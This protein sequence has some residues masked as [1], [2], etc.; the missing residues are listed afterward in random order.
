MSPNCFE[1]SESRQEFPMNSLLSIAAPLEGRSD[2]RLS[3][4]RAFHAFLPL[5]GTRGHRPNAG[6]ANWIK[7]PVS[8]PLTRSYLINTFKRLIR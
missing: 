7:S 2:C 1:F 6:E 8:R 3:G 5:I 4:L